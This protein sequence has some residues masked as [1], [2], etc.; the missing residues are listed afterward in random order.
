MGLARKVPV[1]S[2]IVKA[3]L[4]GVNRPNRLKGYHAFVSITSRLEYVK[5][6][7]GAVQGASHIC[8]R[9]IQC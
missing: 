1:L 6:V 9:F 2:E 5:G 3:T 8:N 4:K 7:M